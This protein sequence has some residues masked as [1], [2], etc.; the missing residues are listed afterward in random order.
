MSFEQQIVRCGHVIMFIGINALNCII[1]FEVI[2]NQQ[3]QYFDID[4]YLREAY[5]YTTGD[6]LMSDL[7]E[8][9]VLSD[10]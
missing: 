1:L 10:V 5:E 6:F 4:R 9:R 7:V 3:I 2:F 8:P